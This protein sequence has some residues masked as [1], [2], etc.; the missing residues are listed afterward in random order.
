[1]LKKTILYCAILLLGQFIS[2]SVEPAFGGFVAFCIALYTCTLK[3]FTWMEFGTGI[4]LRDNLMQRNI[5]HAWSVQSTWWSWTPFG[6]LVG[7]S[8]IT[9]KYH[10]P[11]DDIYMLLF[12]ALVDSFLVTQAQQAVKISLERT[13][14]AALS[15]QFENRAVPID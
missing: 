5:V 2:W 4:V 14:E 10:I 6:V 1:M 7:L 15:L 13:L 3:P 12:V 8:M 9:S 11:C